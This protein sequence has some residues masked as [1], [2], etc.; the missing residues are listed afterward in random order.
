MGDQHFI[1]HQAPDMDEAVLYGPFG[2]SEEAVE[3]ATGQ[4]ATGTWHD[5][6]PTDPKKPKCIFYEATSQIITDA[7]PLPG[8][9]GVYADEYN[10]YL[11]EVSYSNPDHTEGFSY[12]A[13]SDEP[14]AQAVLNAAAIV[15]RG[16]QIG[17]FIAI[18]QIVRTLIEGQV[19]VTDPDA[20]PQHMVTVYVSKGVLHCSLAD[21]RYH[22]AWSPPTL[23]TPVP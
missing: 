9:W 10:R 13:D 23:L 18:E 3:W 15:A 4:L 2:S 16:G 12:K 8:Q 22:G 6:A 7:S 11:I 5:A 17:A 21:R 1:Y 20:S 19:F 14:L